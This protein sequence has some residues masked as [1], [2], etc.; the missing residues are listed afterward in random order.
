MTPRALTPKQK[1]FCDHYVTLRNGGRAAIE[2]GYSKKTCYEIAYENL[3][4]PQIVAYLAE[5]EGELKRNMDISKGAVIGELRAAIEV[6]KSKQD[7]G[8]MIRGWVEIAKML[9]LYAAETVSVTVKAESSAQRAKFEAMS[10]EQL[11]AIVEGKET[12]NFAT[13]S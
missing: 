11:L 9:G 7:G 5:K 10:D 2:A 6:A 13:A 3:R 4:K 12:S 1:A 8:T